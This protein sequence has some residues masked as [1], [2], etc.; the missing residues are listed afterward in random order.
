M[1]GVLLCVAFKSGV[2]SEIALN[3]ALRVP[4]LSAGFSSF[5]FPLPRTCP[6]MISLLF[7]T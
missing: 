7:A 2:E 1:D 4:G 5:L 6:G 3:A